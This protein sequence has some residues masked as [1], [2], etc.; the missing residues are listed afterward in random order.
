M[1]KLFDVLCKN[2]HTT[3]AWLDGDDR[4]TECSECGEVAERQISAPRS[5]LDVASGEF[6]GAT[7]KWLRDR[8][9]K[10]AQEERNKANHG[11]PR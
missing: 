6:P 5:V 11:S 1:A 8:K 9:S 3:E 4:E 2:G 10:I 7:A